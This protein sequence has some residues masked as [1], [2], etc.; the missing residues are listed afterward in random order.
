[1]QL[2]S[3]SVGHLT[4]TVFEQAGEIRLDLRTSWGTGLGMDAARLPELIEALRGA[5][6]RTKRAGEA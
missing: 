4:V 3:A 2:Y 5:E 1:M 6:K